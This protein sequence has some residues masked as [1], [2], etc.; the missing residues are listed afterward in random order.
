VVAWCAM[1]VEYVKYGRRSEAIGTIHEMQQQCLLHS[2]G[3]S[4]GM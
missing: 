1:I 3:C 2:R 4:Q